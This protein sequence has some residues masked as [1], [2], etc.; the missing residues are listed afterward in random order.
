LKE[1]ELKKIKQPVLF[2]K[3]EC[4]YVPYSAYL[5]FKKYI[6]NFKWVIVKDAWH[7]SISLEKN[8]ANSNWDL[9]EEFYK[10]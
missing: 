5:S 4:D 10:N 6:K 7:N 3:W 8:K 9:I 2:F 1:S